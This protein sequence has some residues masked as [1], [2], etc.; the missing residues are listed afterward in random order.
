MEAAQGPADIRGAL[1]AATPLIV[2]DY[3][4]GSA[5]LALDWFEEIREAA[6][7]PRSYTPRP[8]AVVDDDALMSSV[9]TATTALHDL[10]RD[11]S[12]MTDDLLQQATEEALKVLEPAVQRDVAAGFWDTMT[13]NA[14]EDPDAVG[15][16][17]F[18][19][20]NAC[21]FCLMLAGRG[22][23]YTEATAD[24]AAHTSC[25]CVVGPSYDT[26]APRADVMQYL[27]SSKRRTPQQQAALR[28]YLNENFPDAPG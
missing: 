25:H 12:R 3:I 8:F 5:A 14:A 15:W 20:A 1:F 26:E 13:E 27:A 19:R 11:I 9:A 10:E 4:D 17:R 6:R 7:P 16:Q 18:A 2:S 21:K 28:E 24:F 22:A 23:V